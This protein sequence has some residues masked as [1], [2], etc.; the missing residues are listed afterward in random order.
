VQ[1]PRGYWLYEKSKHL[2]VSGY[3]IKAKLFKSPQEFG[4]HL[5]WLL[6]GSKNYADCCCVHCNAPNVNKISSANEGTLIITPSESSKREKEISKVTPVPVPT[7]VGQPIP[8]PAPASAKAASTQPAQVPSPRPPATPTTQAQLNNANTQAQPAPTTAAAVSQPPQWPMRSSLVLRL[9]E[10]VWFQFGSSWRLGILADHEQPTAQ[11]TYEIFHIAP[12][13][14]AVLSQQNI[15]KREQEIRPF[16]TFSVPPVSIPELQNK[17]F[18]EAP[19]DHMFQACGGD[20]RKIDVLNL[21]ASKMGALK[22]DFSYSLWTPLNE[23]ANSKTMAYYGAFV[24]AER[25]EIGDSLRLRML[26]GEI[27]VSPSNVIFGLR[28]IFTT[29]DYPGSVFFRGHLFQRVVGDAASVN[30]V[31]DQ[32]LPQAIREESAFRN[33]LNPSQSLRWCLVAMNVVLKEEAICGRFYPTALIMPLLNA[34][35][36]NEGLAQRSLDEVRLNGRMEATAPYI[37][38]KRNRIEALGATV[39]QGLQIKLPQRIVQEVPTGYAG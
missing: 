3:P 5:L 20:P 4:I 39:R 13:G 12:L 35:A 33:S 24:G 36:F 7:V 17:G 15:Q 23:D 22:V 1:F 14:H 38:R 18:D 8:K 26:P 32:D 6:S 19:W 9:G 16:Y 30:F 29:T 21:D 28:N 37:G 34:A 2:W 25:F 11:G 27:N 31:P 10:L